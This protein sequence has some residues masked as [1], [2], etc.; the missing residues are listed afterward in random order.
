MIELDLNQPRHAQ[1]FLRAAS[2]FLSGW[3]KEW[4]ADKLS[5]MLLV[6]SESPDSD[7]EEAQRILFWQALENWELQEGYGDDHSLV[8]DLIEAV[9]V[10]M[11]EFAG[12]VEG[13]RN[14]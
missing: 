4:S 5:L 6:D 13:G 8:L 1:A 12:E 14:D 10:D 9:A 2:H 11:L 3:P 7:K